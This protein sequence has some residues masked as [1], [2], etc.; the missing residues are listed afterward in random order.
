[1]LPAQYLRKHYVM[2]GQ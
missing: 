1:M 2:F